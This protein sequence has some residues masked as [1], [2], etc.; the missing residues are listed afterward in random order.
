[1]ITS[2]FTLHSW[3]G[4]TKKWLKKAL[5]L[6]IFSVIISLIFYTIFRLIFWSYMASSVLG[7]LPNE[8]INNNTA[9]PV[10]GI[11][12]FLTDAF[13]SSNG[14]GFVLNL[15]CTILLIFPISLAISFIACSL[16][17]DI[18]IGKI[19]FLKSKIV[20][21]IVVIA[22]VLISIFLVFSI[23]YKE[24][25]MWLLVIMDIISLIFISTLIPNYLKDDAPQ[26]LPS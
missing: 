15:P 26:I 9:T 16:L 11:Q 25:L 23:F 1:L 24:G 21:I 12:T 2:A 10:L 20:K 17:M 22:I 3:V 4:K 18:E 7:V 13:R 8:A 14:L 19:S 5:I 6:F